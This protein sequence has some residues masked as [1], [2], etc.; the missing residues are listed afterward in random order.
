MLKD[1]PK[2]L[3]VLAAANT[4]ER[5]GYY[6]MLA[7]FV[8]YL[9]ARF[10]WSAGFAGQ[11]YGGFLAAVYFL[12]VLGG[13]IAD[14]YFGYGKTITFGT[15]IMFIGYALLATMGNQLGAMFSA[16]VLIALGTGFFKGNLQVLVGNLYDNPKY[17]KN[18]DLA[19]SIFY[20]CINI[21]AFFAPSMAD[22]ITEY[23]M[24]KDDLKYNNDMPA[25]INLYKQ[26]SLKDESYVNF[27][28][29]IEQQN[30]P[31]V[32]T[33]ALNGE[34]DKV[35]QLIRQ[36]STISTEEGTNTVPQSIVLDSTQQ[37]LLAYAQNQTTDRQTLQLAISLNTINKT[38][39]L[40]FSNKYLD[41][42]CQSYQYGFGVACFSLIISL[43][44]FL[45]F[46]KFYKSADAT[47]R[48]KAA[49][50]G[51]KDAIVIELTPK[52]TKER[53]VALGL[54]FA[55]VIFFWMSFHQNGLTLTYFARDYTAATVSGPTSLLFSLYSL[56]P[57]ILFC[58]GIYIFI[59]GVRKTKLIGAL[60]ALA[61]AIIMYFVYQYKF[62]GVTTSIT[63]QIFQQFNPMFII[64]LTPV[65]VSLF[66]WL[67][68][69]QKEPSAPRKIGIG[70]IIAAVGFLVM[71]IGSI[72]LP[73]PSARSIN[74]GISP[75]WLIN[76]YLVLT[77][78]ELF[79][80][81]MGISFVSKV[82]PPKYKGLMQGC[83]FAA[84]AIGNYLV[85]IIGYFWSKVSLVTLWGILIGCCALSAL[86]IFSVMKRLER[87]TH[88]SEAQLKAAEEAHKQKNKQ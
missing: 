66:S 77:C 41:T 35:R 36:D 42:L 62:A 18:R 72:G 76:T 47:E 83:W 40:N 84:T 78:A 60:M 64:I 15:I 23:I 19:F 88:E 67:N 82:A 22:T 85:G 48:E 63:P 9:Q 29:F 51:D 45:G 33:A 28:E 70:M 79:L 6:T 68:T 39:V 26:D 46:K 57:F 54:V 44:I 13:Y 25:W 38:E 4:G 14:K 65:F 86:F 3:F 2:G 27:L 30:I 71:L 12:P 55:V 24:S 81:P 1:H 11:I 69:K 37:A 56:V 32:N 7:I 17:S 58:Y 52:Q 80:S 10:G 73:E 34:A 87:V 59:T 31:V 20:M 49:G 43:L 75:Y 50:K 61:C 53:L 21:G 16:L 8:L 5:F 74:P